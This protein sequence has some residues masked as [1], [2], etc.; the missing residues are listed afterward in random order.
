MGRPE[1]ARR[2]DNVA[3]VEGSAQNRFE[4]FGDVADDGDPRRLE[5]EPQR[6][7]R[8]E[9]PVQIGSLAAHELAA[10]DD[11]DRPRP[12]QPV[13]RIVFVGVTIA[14]TLRPAGSDTR[15]PASFIWTPAGRLTESQKR[16]PTRKF[17]PPGCSVP[18]N[19][20]GPVCD[21]RRISR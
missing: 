11:D 21:P 20:T 16:F 17:L 19:I 13:T 7:T 18:W 12:A 1:A 15:L 9:R 5:T 3:L 14:F 10:R 2:Q 6:L 8:E 4:L